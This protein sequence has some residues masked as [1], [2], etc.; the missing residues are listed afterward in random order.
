MQSL[1]LL[2]A[3]SLAPSPRPLELLLN[4]VIAHYY[5]NRLRQEEEAEKG[6]R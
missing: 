3:R 4:S 1:E 6:R 2:P 5:K